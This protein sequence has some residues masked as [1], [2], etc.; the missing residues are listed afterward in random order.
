MGDAMHRTKLVAGT[1]AVLAGL[2]LAPTSTALAEDEGAPGEPVPMA[3]QNFRGVS[4][5]GCYG[6]SNNPHIS[7]SSATLGKIK[8]YAFSKCSS[9]VASLSIRTSLWRHRWWGY[10]EVDS[11]S[12]T[13]SPGYK[14]GRSGVYSCQNN[15]WRTVGEH[16]SVEGSGT[17]SAETMNYKDI[18]N[19]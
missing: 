10:E 4:P 17:Y 16:T 1:I 11:K 12:G 6:Q 18:T 9:N 15:T 13:E 8:G 3:G 5:A 19:C 14:I 7:T 2:L